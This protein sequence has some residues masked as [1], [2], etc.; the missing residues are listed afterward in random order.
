VFKYA[1]PITQNQELE[2]INRLIYLQLMRLGFRNTRDGTYHFKNI[3]ITAFCETD[4]ELTYTQSIEIY[5]KRI[6]K[7]PITIRSE[8]SQTF[9]YLNQSRYL[10]K[11]IDIF[12]Y[13]SDNSLITPSS[14]YESFEAFLQLKNFKQS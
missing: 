1:Y 4:R 14:L 9:C 11:F 8:I 10:S 2:E 6:G 3:I 12:N 13:E 5:S 7:S